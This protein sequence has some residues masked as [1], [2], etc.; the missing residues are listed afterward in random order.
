MWKMFA[1]CAESLKTAQND[2]PEAAGDARGPGGAAR[3][4]DHTVVLR[5][6]RVGRA[7]SKDG[8]RRSVP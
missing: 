6:G 4:G 2:E 5:E 3:D 7:S 8:K 1:C